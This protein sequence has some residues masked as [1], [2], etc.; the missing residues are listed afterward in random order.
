VADCLQATEQ[1]LQKHHTGGLSGICAGLSIVDENRFSEKAD[2]AESRFN[3]EELASKKQSRNNTEATCKLLLAS[4]TPGP[5]LLAKGL[6]VI[7]LGCLCLLG[8]VQ[9]LLGCSLH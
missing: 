7:C 1:K 3:T 5:K 2:S 6:Y 9:S 8:L 4:K